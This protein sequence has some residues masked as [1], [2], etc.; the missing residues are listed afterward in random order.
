MGPFWTRPVRQ[1][2]GPAKI[3]ESSGTGPSEIK[4]TYFSSKNDKIDNIKHTYT[5]NTHT[6]CSKIHK[7]GCSD[8]TWWF[9]TSINFDWKRNIF[10]IGKEGG[11]CQNLVKKMVYFA[12]L[13]ILNILFYWSEKKII[14][15]EK[16][17]N[18]TKITE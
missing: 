1:T 12:F 5:V 9:Q 17:N 16:T 4:I 10:D 6:Q 8:K 18:K 2:T 13:G 7:I 11:G 14:N 15:Q 3:I